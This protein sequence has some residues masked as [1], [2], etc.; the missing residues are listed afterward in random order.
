MTDDVFEDLVNLYLDKEINPAQL[1]ILRTELERNSERRKV[2]ECYCR[3]HQATHLA[4]LTK[5]PVIPQLNSVPTLSNGKTG[6]FALNKQIWAAGLMIAVLGAVA[7]VYFNGRGFG[8]ARITQDQSKLLEPIKKFSTAKSADLTSPP[9][10]FF[11]VLK[12]QE[13]TQNWSFTQELKH[14]KA[15]LGVVVPKQ[16]AFFTW[17]DIDSSSP[18]ERESNSA[19]DIEYSSYEFKR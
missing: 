8:S 14:T 19:F 11:R 1:G 7:T 13:L 10:E 15:T 3:M 6:F 4:A 12:P 18:V 16:H 5:C 9:L 2:F 17:R